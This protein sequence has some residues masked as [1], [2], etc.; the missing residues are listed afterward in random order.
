MIRSEIPKD[1]S[2]RMPLVETVV[3]HE[4]RQN[5]HLNGASAQCR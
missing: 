2:N 4:L 5:R 1:T 3:V